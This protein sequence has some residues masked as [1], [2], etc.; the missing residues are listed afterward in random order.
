MIMGGSFVGINWGSSNLRAYL[1]DEEGITI[2]VIERSA[3]VTTL[4]KSGIVSELN[5]IRKTWPNTEATYLSGMIGSPSGWKEAP[6][7]QCQVGLKSIADELIGA[8]I[9]EHSVSIVPGVRCVTGWGDPD[10]MRG[11]EMEILGLLS[12][13]PGL[14]QQD[15]FMVLP[16]THTKWAI[17]SS[18]EIKEFFTSMSSEIFDHLSRAGLL[19]SVMTKE[20]EADASFIAGVTRGAKDGAALGRLLFGVR[21]KVI[22][23]NLDI[24]QSASYARGLLIGAEIADALR[25][26]PGLRRMDEIPL[27]GNAKLCRLYKFALKEFGIGA[28]PVDTGRVIVA[29]YFSLHR[30]LRGEA[31]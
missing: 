30:I 12:L 3:G 18:G 11:E 5:Q 26:M 8:D 19:S 17:T 1:I 16:G 24:G 2:D 13:E 15:S 21:A 27:L 28:R 29:G 6:Y 7:V 31:A 4:D 22:G 23:G 14:N 20:A 25:L 10:I 9:G